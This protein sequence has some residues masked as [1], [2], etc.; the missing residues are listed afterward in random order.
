M[1]QKRIFIYIVIGIGI[2]VY[3]FLLGISI[4]YLPMSLFLRMLPPIVVVGLL[5]RETPWWVKCVIAGWLLIAG[6]Y[7]LFFN[8]IIGPL[9]FAISDRPINVPAQFYYSWRY[10]WVMAYLL[11]LSWTWGLPAIFFLVCYK[12]RSVWN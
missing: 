4:F 1:S 12:T 10:F 3:L 8:D 9:T 2:L 6:I 5:L 11:Q 7:V